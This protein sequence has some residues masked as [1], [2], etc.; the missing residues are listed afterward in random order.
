MKCKKC[1]FENVESAKYCINCGERLDDNIV[2]PKCAHTVS[3]EAKFCPTCGYKIPHK[4]VEKKSSFKDTMSYLDGVFNKVFLICVIVALS[5]SLICSLGNY[6]NKSF[7]SSMPYDSFYGLSFYYL[8]FNWINFANIISSIDMNNY[9]SFIMNLMSSSIPFILV[10]ANIVI[11]F[12][13]GI[14][15]IISCCNS[16]KTNNKN[17]PY[18]F[19]FIVF[20]CNL[21]TV[22]SLLGMTYRFVNYPTEHSFSISKLQTL[23]LTIN[24]ILIVLMLGFEI[25]KSFDKNKISLFIEK[26]LSLLSFIFV[27]DIIN[28]LSSFS[29]ILTDLSSSSFSSY[30]LYNYFL[31]YFS[32]IQN[33]VTYTNSFIVIIVF[34]LVA[35]LFTSFIYGSLCVYGVFLGNGSFSTNPNAPKYKIPMYAASFMSTLFVFIRTILIYIIYFMT[36]NNISTDYSFIVDSEV[37]KTFVLSLFLLGTSIASCSII[38]SYKTYESIAEKTSV[39]E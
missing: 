35:L 18:K 37:V 11:T 27:V 39:V 9:G 22:C 1:G 7:I 16:I 15:G 32:I 30:T 23:N 6:V 17:N 20:L 33:G 14:K 2:C 8:I 12:I 26:I 28:S 38:R 13:F 4:N 25:V 21:F 34:S 24:F 5:L 31:S 10:L 19:L 36:L 3:N 29:F